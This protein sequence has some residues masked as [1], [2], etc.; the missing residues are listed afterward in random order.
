M[1]IYATLKDEKK[2]K[3]EYENGNMKYSTSLL[4]CLTEVISKFN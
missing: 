3:M 2:G 1:K 4:Y